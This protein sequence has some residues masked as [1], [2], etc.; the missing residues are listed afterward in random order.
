MFSGHYSKLILYRIVDER[1]VS[2]MHGG[3]NLIFCG[4]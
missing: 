4:F 2:V 3:Q 1:A